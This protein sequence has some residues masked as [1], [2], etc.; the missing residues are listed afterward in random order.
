[1]E[2]CDFDLIR[3]KRKKNKEN[4][5]VEKHRKNSSA[6]NHLGKNVDKKISYM[7]EVNVDAVLVG[8]I[9][10]VRSDV[11]KAKVRAVSVE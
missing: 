2:N 5:T 11:K 9:K 4:K 7:K 8:D 3:K 10:V 1:M 6:P